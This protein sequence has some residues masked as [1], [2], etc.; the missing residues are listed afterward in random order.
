MKYFTVMINYMIFRIKKLFIKGEFYHQFWINI[1]PSVIIQTNKTSKIVFGKNII[2]ERYGNI[3][4]LSKGYLK[5]GDKCYF[6]KNVTISCKERIIIGNNCLFGP[7]VKIYDNDH[8]FKRDKGVSYEHSTKGITIG[9]NC[10]IASNVVILKGTQIGDNCVIGAGCIVSGVI[11][12]NSI[13]K[14]K[15]DLEISEVRE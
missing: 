4:V 5:I 14:K 2:F 9:S 12:P 11:P 1:H 13:V 7:D 10:W 3:D 8:K 15:Y 6:N